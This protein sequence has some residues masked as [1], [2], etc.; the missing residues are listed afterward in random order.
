MIDS[1]GPH[2]TDEGSRA[3]VLYSPLNCTAIMRVAKSCKALLGGYVF[4]K[5][6]RERIACS[7]PLVSLLLFFVFIFFLFFFFCSRVDLSPFAKKAIFTCCSV[8]KTG[9]AMYQL[10]GD[11]AW[12]C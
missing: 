3:G 6:D 5:R 4:A 10:A 1:W 9:A 2:H 12:W 11:K 8:D 7:A